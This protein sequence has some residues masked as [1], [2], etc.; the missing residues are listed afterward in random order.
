MLWIDPEQELFFIF[1]SNRVHPNGKGS[2]NPLAGRIATVVA[3]SI[4]DE[5]KT[6]APLKTHRE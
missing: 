4:R 1:L 2:V 3:A 6:N 5:R